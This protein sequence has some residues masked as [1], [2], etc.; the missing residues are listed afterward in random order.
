MASKE[1]IKKISINALEK[2]VEESAP[3]VVNIEWR[4]LDVTVSRRLGFA[5]MMKFVDGVVNLCFSDDGTYLP[6]IMDFAI[7][8]NVLEMYANFTLPSNIE[9]RY[10]L[11]YACDAYSAIMGAIDRNQFDVMMRA[12]ED[13]ADNRAQANIEAINRQMNELYAAFENLESRLSTVFDGIDGDTMKQLIGA[14]SNGSLDE[15][16]LM[17][18]YM[19]SKKP[20]DTDE[21]DGG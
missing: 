1:K 8:C 4:G 3:S 5:D 17:N 12:I 14:M 19:E 15:T 20:E 18:A 16:K 6:E 13:K 9:K 2:C 21:T 11:V 10:E 7:R